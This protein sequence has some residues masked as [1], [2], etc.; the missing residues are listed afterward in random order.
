M[1]MCGGKPFV[2]RAREEDIERASCDKGDI[3]LD[4][5]ECKEVWA[6]HNYDAPDVKEFLRKE[7]TGG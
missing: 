3:I 1:K 6:T 2:R 4:C 5:P 7:A